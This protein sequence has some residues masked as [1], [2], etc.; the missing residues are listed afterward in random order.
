MLASLYEQLIVFNFHLKAIQWPW[1][2]TA[3]YLAV[4]IENSIV[5]GTKE[6]VL[7]VNPANTTAQ[8]RADI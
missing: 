5:T 1:W 8:V 7:L 3:H 6:I 4:F 2:W